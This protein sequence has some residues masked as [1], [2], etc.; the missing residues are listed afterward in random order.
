MRLYY[1]SA[2]PYV[3]KVLV[4]A[5]ETGLADRIAI[6]RV[7]PYAKD[8][9]YRRI[10]PLSRIPA[11]VLDD[12]R[13]LIDSLVICCHLDG[14]HGGARLLPVKD[15]V[16]P[17]QALQRHAIAN[18]IL[19]AALIL[20]FDQRR[21]IDRPE[22]PMILRQYEA[23]NA[24]MDAFEADADVLGGRVDLAA[25]TLGCACG[26]LDFRFPQFDWR[27]SRPSLSAWYQTFSTRPSMQATQPSE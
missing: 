24:A 23:I 11:L 14:L 5:H 18:G 19:D 16:L 3:R 27:V 22:D 4:M 8:G 15:G 6:E 12:G 13:V 10:N 2:S 20:R 26:F 1:S 17:V 9:Q 7:N 21:G 25:I